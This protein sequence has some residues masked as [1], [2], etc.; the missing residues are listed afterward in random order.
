MNIPSYY[1]VH[2]K[3]FK[4]WYQKETDPTTGYMYCKHCGKEVIF[5]GNMIEK[6]LERKIDD[7]GLNTDIKDFASW[8]YTNGI[9]FSY[10]GKSG[11][12]PFV[13]NIVKRYQDE[14]M[15]NVK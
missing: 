13:E 11:E 9:D 1:C 6:M 3:R 10:M 7:N 2:C 14:T 5:V 8:C 12:E 4:K 15:K